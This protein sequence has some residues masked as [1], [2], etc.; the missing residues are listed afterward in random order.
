MYHSASIVLF[1]QS[2]LNRDNFSVFTYS[3]IYFIIFVMTL[4][5]LRSILL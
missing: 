5:L 3:F 4:I 2:P 1:L